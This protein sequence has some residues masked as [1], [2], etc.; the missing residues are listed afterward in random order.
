MALTLQKSI[1]ACFNSGDQ[2][3]KTHAKEITTTVMTPGTLSFSEEQFIYAEGDKGH[4]K[5][6][7][8]KEGER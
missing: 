7:S 4:L 5:G 6:I 1:K 8:V 3:S 2:N